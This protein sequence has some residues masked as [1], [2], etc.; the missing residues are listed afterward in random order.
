MSLR[1]LREVI[2]PMRITGDMKVGDVMRNHPD[3]RGVFVRYGICDCCG[4]ELSIEETA[5]GKNIDIEMLL[6]NLDS[7]I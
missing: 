4:G 2:R 5:Q 1:A 3:T 7:A 6:K